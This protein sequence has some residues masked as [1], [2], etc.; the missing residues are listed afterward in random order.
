MRVCVCGDGV[1]AIL[2][3]DIPSGRSLGV[4][5]SHFPDTIERLALSDC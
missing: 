5:V 2:S 4:A 3:Y 1:G